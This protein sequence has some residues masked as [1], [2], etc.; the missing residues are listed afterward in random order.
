[1]D[2]LIDILDRIIPPIVVERGGLQSF[3][4][5]EIQTMM[6]PVRHS[7]S[8]LD[9]TEFLHLSQCTDESA[10]SIGCGE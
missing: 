1:M 6:E 9:V 7:L 8:G 5:D 10:V 4:E 2:Q 3:T